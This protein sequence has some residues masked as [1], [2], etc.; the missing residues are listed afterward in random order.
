[1][2]AHDL[3]R[4]TLA[5]EEEASRGNASPASLAAVD[6][7]IDRCLAWLPEALESMKPAGVGRPA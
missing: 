5:V 7:E 6:R 1:M 2:A 4:A 3:A